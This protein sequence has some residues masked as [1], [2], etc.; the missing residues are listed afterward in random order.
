MHT[1]NPNSN[2]SSQ[3]GLRLQFTR[4]CS[5]SIS[6]HQPPNPLPWRL[7]IAR[8]KP[9]IHTRTL[10][11]SLSL[12][13]S[14]IHSIDVISLEN[15]LA[16]EKAQKTGGIFWADWRQIEL[17][18]RWRQTSGHVLAPSNTLKFSLEFP[19]SGRC[20]ISPEI[21][22]V[23]LRR[24]ALHSFACSSCSTILLLFLFY[25]FLTS[26]KFWEMLQNPCDHYV[27]DKGL[28]TGPSVTWDLCPSLVGPGRRSKISEGPVLR[29]FSSV[30]WSWDF[31]TF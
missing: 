24:I 8:E 5:S 4:I 29:S 19:N 10:S 25:N 28:S 21:S 17:E 6:L 30:R 13:L 1:S 26:P 9:N 3:N 12:S 18:V 14:L 27:Q 16:E 20:I 23:V 22:C 7:E 2:P 11:L 31:F 15:M